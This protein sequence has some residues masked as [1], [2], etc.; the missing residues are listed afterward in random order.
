VRLPRQWIVSIADRQGIILAR[1]RDQDRFVGTTL[2]PVLSRQRPGTALHTVTLENETVLRATALSRLS[3]WQVAVNLPVTEAEAALRTHLLLLGIWSAVALLMTAVGAAGFARMVARPLQ[4]AS[5]AAAEL[6]HD[7]AMV[8]VPSHVTE[9]NTL[10]ST[11]QRAGNELSTARAR[12]RLLLD[13]LSH[14][15][16]NLLSVVIAMTQS[17]LASE[18]LKEAREPL[19][20]RLFSLARSHDLILASRWKGAPLAKIVEAELGAYAG[21]VQAQGPDIV[22]SPQA[23]QAITMILHELAT[24]AAKYGALSVPQGQVRVTWMAEGV[25]PRLKLLWQEL[26]GPSVRPP[27]GTG[28]GTALLEGALPEATTRLSY[29]SNGFAYVLDVPVEAVAAPAEPSEP[30]ADVKTG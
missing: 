14:R 30:S 12:Q 19:T 18:D 9:V 20:R 11:L 22:L 5:R 3:G 6:A 21:R 4:S 17:S 24:N 15:V 27:T 2:P 13:E 8:A 28:F 7:R 1:S 29:D 26:G 25:P 10:V 23:T 16:K